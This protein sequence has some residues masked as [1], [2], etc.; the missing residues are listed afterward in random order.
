MRGSQLY[1]RP[2]STNYEV[3]NRRPQSTNFDIIPTKQLM[4]QLNYNSN[5]N[6]STKPPNQLRHSW[7]RSTSV[8]SSPVKREQLF[9]STSTLVSDVSV[10]TSSNNKET[11]CV[12]LIDE[13]IKL[14]STMTS[15]SEVQILLI[16]FPL[17]F[18]DYVTEWLK[19]N[20]TSQ[21]NNVLGS[22]WL[23]CPICLVA[24]QRITKEFKVV[25]KSF[26]ILK[27]SLNTFKKLKKEAEKQTKCGKEL[28]RKE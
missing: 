14:E 6:N 19:F 4:Q 1:K 25:Q 28:C 12:K 5:S 20:M 2:Q 3:I 23:S 22:D 7:M 21:H 26:K 10:V 17:L 8:T 16:K 13:W 18:N 9:S 24:H 15:P 27:D 11:D